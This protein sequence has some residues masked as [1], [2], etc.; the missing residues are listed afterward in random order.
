MSDII[1]L[2]GIF[3]AFFVVIFFTYKGFHLAYVVMVACLIVLVTNSMPIMQTFNETIMPAVGTQAAT[4]LPLYLFGA[5]FGKMFIYSGAAHSLSRFLLNLLGRNATAQ[6]KRMIGFTCVI[7][8]NVI[9]NYV[10]VDP[11][12]S[13]FTMI[14]IATGIMVEADIPRKYM[15]VMLVLGSTLGNVMPGSLAAPNI[16]AQGILGAETVSSWSGWVGGFLFIVFVFITSFFYINKMMKK[17]VAGGMK[18][19]YGPL[20]PPA[21]DESHL[22]PVILTIIPLVVI[23]VTYNLFF[24]TTA[25]LSMAVGC[26]VGILCYGV[27]IPKTNGTSRVMTVVNS[28]NDG[29]TIAGIPA[30]ILLN[31][32][33][34]YAIEAAPSFE[35]IQNT[36]INMPGPALLALSLMAIL[37]LGAAA[38]AAGMLIAAVAAANTFIPVLG[39][40]PDAALRILLLSTTVLDSLPFAGAIVAMMSITGIKYKEGY[41]PIAM[42]TVLFTF[43]GNIIV[44]VLY[45]VFPMLP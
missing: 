33:L 38:S 7:I 6:A 23:P 24:S 16:M 19:E 18:F 9:F 12:A 25:W 39:V 36:F 1:G 42:T 26:V 32:T 41:P 10:G 40:D 29:V 22:P 13:L 31:Y 35:I 8:M 15:P 43:L 2:L 17:D 11:F 45:S 14:G 37:L 21:T 4:L 44:A 5:I 30:I 34:G 28:M 27:Y 3:V 20:E